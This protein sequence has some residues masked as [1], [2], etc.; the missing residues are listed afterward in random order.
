M[1][2]SKR[3]PAM[4]KT[5]CRLRCNIP[6]RVVLERTLVGQRFLIVLRVRPILR[7]VLTAS[8][9]SGNSIDG[10]VTLGSSICQNKGQVNTVMKNAED[11]FLNTPSNAGKWWIIPVIGGG[12]NCDPQN[13][14]AIVDFAKIQ[15]TGIVKTGS[16][17]YIT[18]N[19]QLRS[20]AFCT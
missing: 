3:R 18:A 14:T 20:I 11:F 2:R 19:I 6:T 1:R 7:L 9:C 8:T 10:D 15:V 17:K 13:P 12:G 4:C 5:A 16:P